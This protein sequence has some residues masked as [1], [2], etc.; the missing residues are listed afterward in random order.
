MLMTKLD[1]LLSLDP[2]ARIPSGSRNLCRNPKGREQNEDGAI[3]RGPRQ[4]VRAVTENLW[5]RRREDMP[6]LAGGFVRLSSRAGGTSPASKRHL[7]EKLNC[8]TLVRLL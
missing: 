7:T 4:I 2:L 6:S 1:W 8:I 3:N 5:H